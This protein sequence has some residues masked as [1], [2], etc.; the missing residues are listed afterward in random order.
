MVDD[1]RAER[2][3]R[4]RKSRSWEEELDL[5]SDL[6]ASHSDF[7]GSGS[8][9]YPEKS[10]HSP[11]GKGVGCEE[12]TTLLRVPFAT[13]AHPPSSRLLSGLRKDIASTFSFLHA[14]L[15]QL[16]EQSLR[17]GEVVGFLRCIAEF[18]SGKWATYSK[19]YG[20]N[21]SLSLKR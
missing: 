12:V 5:W 18:E 11:G 7:A 1:Q 21:W 19:F 10:R 9:G 17:K 15:A 13:L 4:W 20:K 3:V 16:V 14:T 6:P 2:R 8:P